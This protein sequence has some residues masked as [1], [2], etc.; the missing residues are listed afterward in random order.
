MGVRPEPFPI[1]PVL[2]GNEGELVILRI[3]VEPRLVEQ[4]LDTLARLSFPVSPQ[5]HHAGP[6]ARTVI[7]FPAWSGRLKAVEAALGSAN[8]A[9]ETSVTVRSMIQE[10]AG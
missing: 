7:E 4:A 8:L 1:R 2:H 3:S 6:G 10:I 9:E 5:L